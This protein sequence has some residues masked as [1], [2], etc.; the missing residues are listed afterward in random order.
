MKPD[1]EIMDRFLSHIFGNELRGLVELAW[2]DPQDGK[3]RHAQLFRL[4]DLDALIAKAVEVNSHEGANAYIGAAIR[5]PDT[6]PFA[7][8]SDENFLCAPAYWVDLDNAEAVKT[9]KQ[10]C[11]RAPANLGV[12]TGRT[13][14]PRAQL[15]WRCEEAITDPKE[16]RGTNAA[17]ARALGGD[18]AVVNPGRIMRLPG[19]I[20][21]PVKSGRIAELV[22]LVTWNDRPPAYVEGEVASAFPLGASALNV[23]TVTDIFG[24]TSRP[25]RWV[26]TLKNGAAEG[27]RNN[28]AAALAGYLFRR[29]VLPAEALEILRC[30]ND[31][32]FSPP[33]DEAELGNVFES[34]CKAELKRRGKVA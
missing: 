23:P 9:A 32:R 25:D 1:P 34:I 31:S 5:H 12:I 7:R 14:H 24:K 19:S 10:N 3:L 17:I 4:D 16:L 15:Y 13:P 18:P 20:A 26:E 21:W 11:G 6:A 22:E 28:T 29:D 30:V 8:A 33:L 2:R 27:E